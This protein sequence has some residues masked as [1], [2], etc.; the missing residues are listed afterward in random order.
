[1][2]K[3]KTPIVVKKI[4]INSINSEILPVL[5]LRL[6]FLKIMIYTLAENRNFT[7]FLVNI[8]PK[9]PNIYPQKIA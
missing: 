4:T 2:C 6:G 8:S 5:N 9:I 7:P 1:M 3:L